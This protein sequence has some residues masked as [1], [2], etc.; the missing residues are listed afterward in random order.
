MARKKNLLFVEKAGFST[1]EQVIAELKA[2]GLSGGRLERV[3]NDRLAG[4]DSGLKD[5]ASRKHPATIAQLK[6]PSRASKVKKKPSIPVGLDFENDTETGETMLMGLYCLRG[7]GGLKDEANEY[8]E[9]KSVYRPT[10]SSFVQVIKSYAYKNRGK[11]SLYEMACWSN[12]DMEQVLRLFEPSDEEIGAL[13][14]RDPSFDKKTGEWKREPAI[15]RQVKVNGNLYE[16]AITAYVKKK[17]MSF[18]IRQLSNGKSNPKKGRPRQVKIALYNT[19]QFFSKMPETTKE[20]KLINDLEKEKE[21]KIKP[22]GRNILYYFGESAY[23]HYPRDLHVIDWQRFENDKEYSEKVRECNI[24]DAWC[25]AKMF[26]V[27]DNLLYSVFGAYS[28]SPASE[29]CFSDVAVAQESKNDNDYNAL[30]FFWLVENVWKDNIFQ[31]VNLFNK[32]CC[33]YAGGLVSVIRAGCSPS[34]FLADISSAYP[35]YNM[36]APDLRDSFLIEGVG[37]PPA[38]NPSN[39]LYE[40]MPFV[41]TDES[42]PYMVFC[43]GRVFVPDNLVTH[44]I[45]TRYRALDGHINQ[46]LKGWHYAFYTKHERDFIVSRGGEFKQEKWVAVYCTG[47]LSVMGKVTQKL[48]DMRKEYK[49]QGKENEQ[50]TCKIAAN[51]M[52]GK[53]WEAIPFYEN[54]EQVGY[55]AGQ[56][57]NP[58]YATYITSITRTLMSYAAARIEDSGGKV[59]L[60]MTDSILWQGDFNNLPRELWRDEKTPGYFEKPDE[61][62][63]CMVAATGLYQYEGAKGIT[64]KTRGYAGFK[65]F[66]A[67]NPHEEHEE[68]TLDETASL[69]EL[70]E[71]AKENGTGRAKIKTQRL[72][73]HK[74]AVKQAEYRNS[75]GMILSNIEKDIDFCTNVGKELNRDLSGFTRESYMEAITSGLVYLPLPQKMCVIQYGIYSPYSEK[76]ARNLYAKANIS[77]LEKTGDWEKDINRRIQEKRKRQGRRD[78]KRNRTQE[79]REYQRE[80][81]RKRRA[82]QTPEQ[83]QKE[84]QAQRERMTRLRQRRDTKTG[85]IPEA[86]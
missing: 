7:P 68:E 55:C 13:G 10:L 11:N 4:G 83:R 78:Y 40:N 66:R 62:Y 42:G 36:R 30:N 1:E 22:L 3:K 67:E 23:R 29:A 56:R 57:F 24:Y 79:R 50:H 28:P 77:T 34:A 60:L 15:K 84:N 63:D 74:L 44:P 47:K 45:I 32:A 25:A 80:R 81:A 26:Q 8:P 31:A 64:Q 59:M 16:I 20:E 18:A 17:F 35:F 58:V 5:I 65:R 19:I 41:E 33:A 14:K 48:L 85:K 6:T 70:A 69:I 51:A 73:S 82:A 2:K 86:L 52:Y 54:D 71:E 21:I 9:R 72:I 43:E 46:S 76:D 27:R 12:F 38:V 75:A 39:G 49:A 61:V 37:R 53:T